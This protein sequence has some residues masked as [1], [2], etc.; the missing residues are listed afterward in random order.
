MFLASDH[1]EHR[2]RKVRRFLSSEPGIA[3]LL[4]AVNFEW[5]VCRAVLFLSQTSNADLRAKMRDYYSL[6]KYKELWQDEV[7]SSG[8][9]LGLAK[10]VRN[11]STVQGAF[12]ARNVL[13]HGKDRFTRNMATPHVDALLKGVRFIDEY[14][15]IRGK[16]LYGRM[17][18][19]RRRVAG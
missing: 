3:L 15:E 10:L 6:E 7:V 5:T 14:C 1:V 17:P 13:V 19:R 11:W 9:P 16:P 2:E 4:A 12:R 8:S 18:I